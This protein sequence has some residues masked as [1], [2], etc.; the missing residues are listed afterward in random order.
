MSVL[1]IR[2]QFYYLET[3]QFEIGSTIYI[4]NKSGEDAVRSDKSGEDALDQTRVERMLLDQ[5]RMAR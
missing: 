3:S 1:Y 2:L 4:L 5:T